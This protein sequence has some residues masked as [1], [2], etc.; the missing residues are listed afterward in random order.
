MVPEPK[1][2]LSQMMFPTQ[3]VSLMVIVLVWHELQLYLPPAM[4]ELAMTLVLPLQKMEKMFFS[5]DSLLQP[6]LV[7][8]QAHDRC[9]TAC[10]VV[11]E[12]R[13]ALCCHSYQREKPRDFESDLKASHDPRLRNPR[14]RTASCR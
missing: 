10:E 12:L 4:N 5:T 1:L 13:L 7:Q 11:R 9:L 8:H 6:K 14:L 2:L 3:V